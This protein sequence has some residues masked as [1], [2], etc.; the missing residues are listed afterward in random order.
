VSNRPEWNTYVDQL[1]LKFVGEEQLLFR[2]VSL[3]I[4]HGQK[5]LILGPNGSGKST[6]LQVLSGLIP[7]S[8]EIPMTA[9]E[10]QSPARWGFVFQDPDTQFCMSYVDEELAFVLENLQTPRERMPALIE[11]ALE[12]VGLQLDNTHTLIQHLSQGMKQRLALAAVLLLQPQTVFLDEPSALLDPEGARQVWTSIRQLLTEQTVIV[13]EHRI[14]AILDWIERIIVLDAE[15]RI[16][17]DGAA[18]HIFSQHRA[19]LYQFGIWYPQVWQEYLVN[20][21]PARADSLMMRREELAQLLDFKGYYGGKVCIE[22]PDVRIYKQ[23]WIAVTG[24]NGAGKSSLLLAL[25]QLIA[26]SGAYRLAGEEIV[27]SKKHGKIPPHLSYVFQN[28]EL[29]FITDSVYEEIAYSLDSR[30]D[31]HQS[32]ESTITELLKDYHLEVN[33]ER[34]PYELSLGQKRR[35]SVL[36]SLLESRSILLLDEPTFGQDAQNTF[37]LLER[38]EQLRENGHTIIMVTHDDRIVEEFATT[39]WIISGGKLTH[40]REVERTR[41]EEREQNDT[42]LVYTLQANL[43]VAGKSLG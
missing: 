30:G 23:E 26:T 15:G 37:L 32:N 43:A 18:A 4:P 14:D 29:Q 41:K 8:I 35:L 39:E 13:V 24:V 21:K 40:I 38:L 36:T 25:A 7:Q 22:V 33:K 1:R 17:A 10:I 3:Y 11:Q 28:P 5:V 31:E 12:H 19:E 16:L 42:R 20:H 9:R 2:D 27:Y 34:H 6:L